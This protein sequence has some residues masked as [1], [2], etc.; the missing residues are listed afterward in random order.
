MIKKEIYICDNCKKEFTDYME[1]E[2][3]ETKCDN[4]HLKFRENVQR[5]IHKAKAKYG[6]IIAS[7]SFK[8]DEELDIYECHCSSQYESYKFEIELEL[9]NGNHVSV[10]DGF[11]ENL[12]LGNYLEEDVIF[13]SLEKAIEERLTLSYEG[14]IHADWESNDGWRKDVIGDV[15][16]S[17]IVDRLEGRKVR[18]EVT[19]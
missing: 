14:V 4:K 11:D 9:S 5:A 2:I 10:Y 18:I 17:D 15:E 12:W 19:E 13:N 1:C 16:I 7:S 3:H 8:T 6:S